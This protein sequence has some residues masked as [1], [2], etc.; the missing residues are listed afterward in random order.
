MPDNHG[1]TLLEAIIS[2]VLA[3]SGM[4]LVFQ[5]IG[6]ASK[7]QAATVELTQAS[8]VAHSILAAISSDTQSSSGLTDG[9]AWTITAEPL[10]RNNRGM[11][12][13][14]IHIIASAASGR[15]VVLISETLRPA[16]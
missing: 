13:I 5:S 15:Q 3:A 6:G 10:A 12:L 8:I 11:E 2:I 7:I 1:F 4:A 9:I 16:L 14:R